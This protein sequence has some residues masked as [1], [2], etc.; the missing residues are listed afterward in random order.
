MRDHIQFYLG[1]QYC[2]VSGFAPETTVLDWLREE[3]HRTGTKEGCNEG[4]CGACTI[5]VVR[6]QDNKL[7]WK[8]VNAC[9]QFLWMLDGAQIFTVEDLRD[10][11]GA[12]HPVQQ[13]M[14]DQHGSQ[15]GFCTPGFVMSM[16]AY[17]KSPSASTDEGAINDALAGNLC[18][19]TGYAPI[20]KAMKQALATTS[21]H[22]DQKEQTIKNRL[23]KFLPRSACKISAPT[24]TVSLPATV[25]ELASIYQDNSDATLVAG[26]TDVGLWVT[27][28]LNSLPHIISI[29]SVESLKALHETDDE[30][31]IGAGVTYSCAHSAI[32]T[33][34]PDAGEVIRRIGSTQVRNAGTVCGNIGNG[35]PIGD[36][37][38]LFIAAEAV[39]VLRKGQ[40]TRSL[41]IEDYFIAYGKQDRQPGEF[42]EALIIPKPDK[43][44]LYRAYKISKRFDQDISALLG[45]FAMTCNGDGIVTH[46]RIA[47]GGMAATP[48]RA[49]A[50]ENAI[51]GKPWNEATLED[52]RDAIQ[53]DFTPLSDM[54]SSEW[55]RRQVAANLLIRFFAETATPTTVE[56]RL[57]GWKDKAYV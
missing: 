3:R 43:N 56:T 55:Y 1:D 6:M 7:Q 19:C 20:V 51:L 5:L 54:R 30:L 50:T 36:G 44:L 23:E 2:Q 33:I 38:P 25:E 31:W 22:F 27:K 15:C 45:V 40:V 26:A 46:I 17:Y 16:V 10:P 39:L 47:F 37:P 21:D 11:T 52:A 48:K 42:I 28:R 8:A 9:I 41:P 34:L 18:R 57:A 53:T 35:S 14:V 32:A 4:D 49:Y 13:A 24:G 12:L 29:G